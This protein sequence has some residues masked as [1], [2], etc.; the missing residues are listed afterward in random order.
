MS[1]QQLLVTIQQSF[2]KGAKSDFFRAFDML[3]PLDLKRKDFGY[4]KL[5]FYLQIY[6][7]VFRK[8]PSLSRLPHAPA[9]VS[10]D[11]EFADAQGEF[12]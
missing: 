1:A 8:H 7:V 6:F 2:D 12:K 3:V 5:E 11:Q 9:T 4:K 10:S